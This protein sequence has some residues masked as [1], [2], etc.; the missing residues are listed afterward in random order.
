MVGCIIRMKSITASFRN[1]DFQNFHK[2]FPLPP[3]TTIVGLLGAAK[4]FSPK[5]AQEYCE[6]NK[7]F[8][9]VKGISKSSAKDLWKHINF[10][11]KSENRGIISKEIL[12]NNEFYL[13]FA[14][15]NNQVIQD[16]KQD[17]LY[18][19]YALTFGMSDSLAKVFKEI[20]INEVAE[21]DNKLE[22]TIIEGDLVSKLLKQMFLG[23]DFN[24]TL[25]RREPLGFNVPTRFKY[26]SDSDTRK[27]AAKRFFSFVNTKIELNQEQ[28]LGFKTSDNQHFI[29]IFPF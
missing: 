28:F 3:P 18:P 17:F 10:N 24:F 19:K 20:E 23:E 29:P 4:G 7:L 8:F 22:N 15:E 12:F 5:E 2:T 21:Y 16:L 25:S 1:S 6:E 27:V 11:E 9:G 14:S 13:V 26:E